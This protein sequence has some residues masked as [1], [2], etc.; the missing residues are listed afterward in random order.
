MDLALNNRHWLIC[1]K[2]KPNQKNYSFSEDFVDK[3]IW[4]FAVSFSVCFLEFCKVFMEYC[5]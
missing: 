2:T 3:R 4:Q 1:H 5:C